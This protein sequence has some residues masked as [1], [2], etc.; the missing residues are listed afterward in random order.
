M[1]TPTYGERKYGKKRERRNDTA[2]VATL[3]QLLAKGMRKLVL[4]S[5]K[6]IEQVRTIFADLK[7]FPE[8]KAI[9]KRTLLAQFLSQGILEDDPR[10]CL[11]LA[12]LRDMPS[13]INRRQLGLALTG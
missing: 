12:R 8:A 11:T 10:I 3:K 9:A 1:R 5:K 4:Q 2:E 6:H 7:P 13:K